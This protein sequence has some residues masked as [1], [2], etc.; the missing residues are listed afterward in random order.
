MCLEHL[1]FHPHYKLKRNCWLTNTGFSMGKLRSQL[2]SQG[3]LSKVERGP[4]ELLQP[5]KRGI[6]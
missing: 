1:D 2:G 3:P 6:P 4:W 5:L